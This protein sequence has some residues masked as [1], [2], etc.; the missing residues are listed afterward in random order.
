MSHC[1]GEFNGTWSDHDAI[2]KTI[3]DKE[4]YLIK[5]VDDGAFWMAWHDFVNF[6]SDLTICKL[7]MEV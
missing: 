1:L 6:F 4:R 2:W 3:P 5:A 7:P